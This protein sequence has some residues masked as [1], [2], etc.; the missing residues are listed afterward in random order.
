[1]AE[2][3]RLARHIRQQL[4][5]DRELA[6]FDLHVRVEDAVVHLSGQ[7]ATMAQSHRARRLSEAIPGA[8]AVVNATYVDPALAV[9]HGNE[10][11]QPDDATLRRRVEQTLERDASVNG[12]DIQ[13]A[14]EN[15]TVTLTGTVSGFGA[16][17]KAVRAVRDL[18]GVGR[19]VDEL[20]VDRDF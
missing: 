2:D 6:P 4:A 8:N 19:V 5:W 13:A 3:A 18:Y 1:M 7:V 10:P 14:V 15:G 11:P 9:A 16:K 20:A 17:E 12:P